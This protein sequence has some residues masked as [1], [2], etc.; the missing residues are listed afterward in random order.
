[1]RYAPKFGF[2]VEYVKD[3]AAAQRFYVDVMGLQVQRAHPS[4]V[5]FETFAIASDAPMGG[6]AEQELYWLVD[7][8]Q[9]A[10]DDLSS[11]AV[12]SLALQQVPFGKVFGIRDSEG[13]PRYLLELA[14]QRP[15]QRATEELQHEPQ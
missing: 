15:S 6:E 11:K 14:K 5:Q 7:D 4:F 12:V 10:F 13:R 1:M 9:A 3:I 8:A 2:V